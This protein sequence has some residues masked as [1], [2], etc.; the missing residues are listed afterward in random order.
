MRR[1]AVWLFGAALAVRPACPLAASPA[2]PL[3]AAPAHAL[4]LAD[5]EELVYNVAWIVVPG[6]GRITVDAHA[7]TDAGGRRTLEVLTKTETRGLA[8]M[9][10]PFEAWANSVYDV[11][12]GRLIRFDET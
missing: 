1:A 9:L 8:H 5:G 4:P 12:T 10:L 11:A 6:A 3:P 2:H 7:A